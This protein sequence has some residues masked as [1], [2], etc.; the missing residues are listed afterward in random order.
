MR[1][2]LL[3]PLLMLLILGGVVL[4]VYSPVRAQ[5]FAQAPAT[6]QPA[7]TTITLIHISDIHGR[8]V[9]RPNLRSDGT[10]REEGGLARMYAKIEEIRKLAK[11]S[12]LINTGDTIQGSAEALFTR[13]QALVDVLNR[14][15]IDVFAPGNWE[16]VYGTQRFLELFGPDSPKAPWNVIAANLYYDGEPYADKTGKRVLPPYL[17]RTVDGVKIGFLGFTTDRGPQVVGRAV[18]KG[19]KFTK[20]DAEVKEFVRV[21]REQEKVDVLVMLSEL[22][23]ANDLRLTEANPGVDFVLSSDMHELTRKPIVGKTG[24]VIVEEGQDGVAVGELTLT[25]RGGKVGKWDWRQ[26]IIDSTIAEDPGIAAAVKEVRKTFVT[27]PDFKP[28]VNPFNG[29][30]LSRPINTVVG[31]TKVPLHRLNFSH[32]TMPAVIEGSSHDFLTDAFRLMADAD[33]GA[34]RGFRYG[35]MIAPGPIKLEDLYHFMPIGPMIAKGAIKG[36]ALKGQIEN[37]VDGSLN[38]KVEAWTGGWLFNFSGVTMDVDP[39][40]LKGSRA[41]NVKVYG[42]QAKEWKPLNPEADYTYASYYYNTDPSLINVVPATN[43][44][45]LKDEKGNPLD[46]VEVVVRYLESLPDK[47]ANPELNRIRLRKPLPT[48]RFGF[49]EIQPFRGAEP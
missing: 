11:H 10:G 16:F 26:H 7:A 37:A 45:V 25:V 12:L 22:G 31:F 27:G 4:G 15:K 34:I 9:P 5:T 18:S 8:L 6:P 43:I 33:I 49:P 42:R 36:K 44:T 35:T 47:T 24:T 2:Q 20:G 38:P 19:F 46:G 28:H 23:P 17:I 1:K 14:F 40:E 39:Y 29:T 3:T 13:G 48:A 30:T 32:E 41:S 21:L